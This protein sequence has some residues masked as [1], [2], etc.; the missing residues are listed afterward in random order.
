M[1]CYHLYIWTS[2]GRGLQEP[3]GSNCVV[4]AVPS[5][6]GQSWPMATWQG[7]CWRNRHSKSH[8]FPT[9]LWSNPTDNQ[10]AEKPID[11]VSLYGQP[12]EDRA[13]WKKG[14]ESRG[15]NGK[16]PAQSQFIYLIDNY[17]GQ[18][19]RWLVSFLFPL[20]QSVDWEQF[21]HANTSMLLK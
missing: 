19:R 21:I 16:W 4:G 18:W 8:S 10:K 13:G 3:G 5:V 11:T 2:K 7:G 9:F 1:S 6:E 20:Q 15:A 12:L 14:G 17:G